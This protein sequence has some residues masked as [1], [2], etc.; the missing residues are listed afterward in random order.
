[1]Q[2]SPRLA[3]PAWAEEEVCLKGFPHALPPSFTFIVE[4]YMS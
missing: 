1:M 4:D 2:V 3:S